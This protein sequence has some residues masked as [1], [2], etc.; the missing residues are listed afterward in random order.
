[1]KLSVPT[2][3]NSGSLCSHAIPFA[4]GA[5][6]RILHVH[7][8]KHS[9][10]MVAR[11]HTCVLEAARLGELPNDLVRIFRCDTPRI[12]VIVLHLWIDFHCFRML[13]VLFCR[14]E[15]K[16]VLELAAVVE[17]KFDLIPVANL[18]VVWRKYHFSVTLLH[19]YFDDPRRRCRVAWLSC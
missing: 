9:G 15:Y 18:N 2:G 16:F 5:T 10:L 8:A 1:M 17:H 12:G 3:D 14:R 4:E 13:E 7:R 19:G 6:S 11:E